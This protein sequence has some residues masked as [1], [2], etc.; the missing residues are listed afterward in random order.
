[1]YIGKIFFTARKSDLQHP[2]FFLT[3]I[4]NLVEQYSDLYFFMVGLRQSQLWVKVRAGLINITHTHTPSL[5]HVK[6]KHDLSLTLTKVLLLPKPNQTLDC[7]V[8]L[9]SVV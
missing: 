3:E 7:R 1:M 2:V 9:G 5:L 6:Q 4:F 8:D